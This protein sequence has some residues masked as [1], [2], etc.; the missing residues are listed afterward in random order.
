M[1]ANT[2]LLIYTVNCIYMLSYL[3]ENINLVRKDAMKWNGWRKSWRW[4]WWNVDMMYSHDGHGQKDFMIFM[5]K[6]ERYCLLCIQHTASAM[7]KWATTVRKCYILQA[8][9]YQSV[10]PIILWAHSKRSDFIA[11]SHTAIA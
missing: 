4:R 6:W 8:K 1:V 5:L 11:N 10:L 7:R 3:G 9:L 2:L